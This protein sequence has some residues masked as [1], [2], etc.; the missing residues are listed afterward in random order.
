MFPEK[1]QSRES[2][3]ATEYEQI[4]T[5]SDGCLLFITQIYYS[6][7]IFRLELKKIF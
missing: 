7:T 2:D 5:S 4:E 1:D 3:D 6:T